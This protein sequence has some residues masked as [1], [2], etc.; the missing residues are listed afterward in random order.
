MCPG[1]RQRWQPRLASS[2]LEGQRPL[3]H[4]WHLMSSC[5]DVDAFARERYAL[6]RATDHCLLDSAV[7]SQKHTFGHCWHG[8]SLEGLTLSRC[9]H[10]RFLDRALLFSPLITRQST[11]APINGACRD[12]KVVD[13]SL[14][15]VRRH[16]QHVTAP[17]DWLPA[18]CRREPPAAAVRIALVL[19]ASVSC[20]SIT[21]HSDVCASLWCLA[22]CR[23]KVRRT[24]M[25]CTRASGSRERAW[26]PIAEG[27]RPL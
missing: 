7:M 17:E 8:R 19:G 27:G 21:R 6:R 2:D 22:T 11:R 12:S 4:A 9:E 26:G 25:S 16:Q 3:H 14:A 24:P 5:T 23:H 15:T 10:L 13:G 1:L 18:V 20:P